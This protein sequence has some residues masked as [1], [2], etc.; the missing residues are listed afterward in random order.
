MPHCRQAYLRLAWGFSWG[1][2]RH[3]L[4][5][6]RRFRRWLARGDMYADGLGLLEHAGKRGERAVDDELED[7]LAAS[8]E[9]T[10]AFLAAED[11]AGADMMQEVAP[12]R[13]ASRADDRFVFAGREESSIGL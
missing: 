13:P 8:G 9:E 10:V 11:G 4:V 3:F 1:C 2:C 5:A 12:G 7:D 6:A